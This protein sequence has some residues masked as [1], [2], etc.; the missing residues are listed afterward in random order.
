MFSF[1]RTKMD[2]LS[3][4]VCL[5][6]SVEPDQLIQRWANFN[7]LPPFQKSRNTWLGSSVSCRC[8]LDVRRKPRVIESQYILVKHSYFI[9]NGG[10]IFLFYKTHHSY[11]KAVKSIPPPVDCQH[12]GSG[13]GFGHSPVPFQNDDLGPNFVV[14][15]VPF[16]YHLLQM[17]LE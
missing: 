4:W 7:I 1:E 17:V 6:L 5:S 8:L 9:R 3:N 10:S 11:S 2:S 15:T 14:Y 16:V 13:V 12:G